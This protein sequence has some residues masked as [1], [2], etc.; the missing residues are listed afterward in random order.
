MSRF[1]AIVLVAGLASVVLPDHVQACG[2]CFS[3]PDPPAEPASKAVLQNAERIFFHQ[4]PDNLRITA[5]VE[6]RYTGLASDFGWVLPVPVKPK[7][8]VGTSILLDRLDTQMAPVH[9]LKE[10]GTE[11]CRPPVQGCQN[12]PVTLDNDTVGMDGAATHDG[13]AIHREPEVQVLEVGQTG[14][15]DYAIVAAKD[16]KPLQDWLKKRKY[17]LPN[18]ALPIIESHVA[19]GDV[20]VAIKL[21]NGA[22]V[23]L[24]KPLVLQ[25]DDAD[26]CVP[27]RLT[28]IAATEHM[29]VVVTLAGKGRAI[30]K[31]LMNVVPNPLRIDV[32][33]GA[34]NYDQVLG[35]AIDEAGG[36]A[37]ATEYAA[38]PSKAGPAFSDSELDLSALESVANLH[39]LAGATRGLAPMWRHADVAAL[40]NK[41]VGLA[42]LLAKLKPATATDA[43]SRLIDCGFNWQSGGGDPC[44]ANGGTITAAKAKATKVNI[45]ALLAA[46]QKEI[47][48]PLASARDQVADSARVT[49]MAM[50]I[51]PKEMDRDPI[52]AFND[53]LPDVNNVHIWPYWRVCTNGWLPVDATRIEYPGL[54]S[55]VFN[56]TLS[57]SGFDGVSSPT[58]PRFA[59]APFA[60]AI[61]L[62]DET[63][64]AR[65]IHPSDIILVDTTII[66]AVPGDPSL[67]KDVSLREVT[68]W[69]PPNSDKALERAGDW[70][71]P[72]GCT[73]KPGY[74]DGYPPTDPP[75]E[76]DGCTAGPVGRPSPAPALILL[77][78]FSLLIGRS[79]TRPR[80]E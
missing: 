32:A 34:K 25:M 18:S 37:F 30:A 4:D 3:P 42:K 12:P 50:R 58:D 38:H 79:R 33:G 80:V 31:N 65:N 21:S 77:L 56:G 69:K 44:T 36:R 75:A 23:E 7:I 53:Q 22:G 48:A 55:W 52:F 68:P 40:Y 62:L 51:S 61:E 60:L 72:E 29:A 24:I 78:L 10:M 16:A 9:I 76:D 43:L 67:P 11:N 66:G 71:Q 2:G 1:V 45:K 59:K 64:K 6:V 27:L 19:K 39:A 47:A 28:S 5:W 41:H 35:E 63:G 20:F 49:R 17:K 54:G 26:P 46:L 57:W 8:T 70:P 14:P 15:Y 13:G 74:K 73:P